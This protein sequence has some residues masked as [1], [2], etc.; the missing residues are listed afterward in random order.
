MTTVQRVA[1]LFGWIFV[2]IGALGFIYAPGMQSGLLLGIFPVNLVHN[3]VHI[4]FG[5]W[6]IMSARTFAGARGYGQMAGILYLVLAVA[7]IFFPDGFGL[8]PL[9]GND[10]WLHA[11]LGVIL[12]FF[13]FTAKDGGMSAAAA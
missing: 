11:A 13:G 5:I 6:G 7:G 1:Q 12:A 9:G 4:L 10:I 2:L 3:I 8:V